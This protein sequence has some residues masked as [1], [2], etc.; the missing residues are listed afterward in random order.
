MP[1]AT[2]SIRSGTSVWSTSSATPG[3]RP[4]AA[5]R[6]AAGRDVLA[7]GHAGQHQLGRRRLLAAGGV[8]DRVDVDHPALEQAGH[9]DPVDLDDDPALGRG[10]GP[11]HRGDRQQ[12]AAAHRPGEHQARR[13]PPPA[14]EVAPGRLVQADR[15]WPA[16]RRRAAGCRRR[17]RGSPTR[18][19]PAGRRRRRPW[20][21]RRPRAGRAAARPA[22]GRPAS[23]PGAVGTRAG[24]GSSD[25]ADIL[26][27]ARA[28]AAGVVHRPL[29]V[30]DRR[31][32]QATAGIL[33]CMIA[34]ASGR[35]PVRA[36]SSSPTSPRS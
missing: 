29:P 20:R 19:A 31:Q 28:R 30:D 22:A 12:L 11:A 14:D 32:P 4:A 24:A 2:A 1:C 36:S 34:T 8:A 25:T 35:P 9:A 17:G 33:P 10:I 16:G 6:A 15:P 7:D 21:R 26:P 27:Y 23:G 5:E 3:L 13:G 18:P